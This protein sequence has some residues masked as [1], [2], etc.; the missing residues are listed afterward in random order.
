MKPIEYLKQLAQDMCEETPVLCADMEILEEECPDRVLFGYSNG[1]ATTFWEGEYE[2]RFEEIDGT[3]TKTMVK[4]IKFC[5]VYCV[6][7]VPD[8][9]SE[10]TKVRFASSPE[11]ALH[12]A[13][14]ECY[15]RELGMQLGMNI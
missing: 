15:N 8:S 4:V 5:H 11:M 2:D 12:A 3:T 10:E 9:D 7:G 14:V 13:M 6:G 1:W